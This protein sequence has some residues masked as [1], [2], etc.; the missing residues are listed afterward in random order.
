MIEQQSIA[1]AGATPLSE[2][3]ADLIRL[4]IQGPP[5]TGKSWAAATFPNPV[6]LDLD[7]KLRSLKDR[8]GIL[9]IPFCDP[10]WV[11]EYN[12]GLYKAKGKFVAPNRRDA[13]VHWLR[14]EGIK[15]GPT[16]TIILD[17]WTSLM[18]ARDQQQDQ[19]PKTLKEGGED[20]WGIFRLKL[21]YCITI[22][23]ILK[24]LSCNVVMTCHE[25]IDRDKEGEANGKLRP[26]AQGQF[27]DQIA[28]HFSDWYRQSVLTKVDGKGGIQMI[29]G[30]PMKEDIGYYWQVKSDALF[31]ACCGLK[32]DNKVKYIKADYKSL[33]QQ[34]IS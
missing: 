20:T 8:P 1:I 16:Y 4:G 33:I 7:N 5:G 17:S 14:T 15:L 29:N 27:A 2:I 19:E 23:E 6:F 31:N 28:A 32:L 3:K 9:R 13:V 10:L 22:M 34:T 21:A 18:N 26:L 24:G 12:N 25:T 11:S 30:E